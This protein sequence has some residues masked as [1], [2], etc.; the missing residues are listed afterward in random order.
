MVCASSDAEVFWCHIGEV[1]MVV[2]H[3]RLSLTEEGRGPFDAMLGGL[4]DSSRAEEG[5][6]SYRVYRSVETPGEVIFVEEWS[7]REMLDRYFQTPLYVAFA[8]KLPTW[9]S[10]PAEIRI[11]EVASVSEGI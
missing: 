8:D 7:N 6:I 3:A 11:H 2:L 1:D 9:V 4:L 5:C 10:V